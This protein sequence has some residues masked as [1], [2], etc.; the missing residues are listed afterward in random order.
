MI[1]TYSL[2]GAL[3]LLF[4]FPGRI[5]GLELSSLPSEG[6]F[7]TSGFE[8]W[9]PEEGEVLKK[10]GVYL[11]DKSKFLP[12][13]TTSF[14]YSSKPHWI[15][16]PI[17]N[18]G[19]DNI[20]WVL[21]VQ[22]GP[23]DKLDVYL[24]SKGEE[25]IYK[26][27]DSYPFA[28]RPIQYRFPSFPFEISPGTSDEIFIRIESHSALNFPMFA[29]QRE[30]F[31]ARANSE[32]ILLG[33]Y[34][35]SIL[36]MA[37][38]NLFLFLSTRE[39]IYFSFSL[40]VGVGA[41]LQC[42]LNGYAFQYL[43]PNATEWASKSL[44]CFIYLSLSTC[45]DF[46]R[47]YFSTK[48]TNPRIDLALK[49]ILSACLMMVIASYFIPGRFSIAAFFGISSL[50]LVLVLYLGFQALSLNLHAAAFF[51]SAW[52][53]LLLGDFLFIL[54]LANV[55]PHSFGLAFWGVEWGSSL[56]ILLLALG[57]ADRVSELSKDLT[58]RVKDLNEAKQNVE[59]SEMR[60]RNLFEGAEELLITLDQEGKI[61]DINRS[62]SRMTGHLP[63]E[64]IGTKF[65][66]LLFAQESLNHSYGS[67]IANDR[68]EEQLKT[69]K[70]VEFHAEL[71]HKYVME[72]KP[73][74]IRL[75][76]FESEGKKLFLGKISEISEDILSRF[77]LSE[78]MHFTLNNYL[79]NADV[80][81]RQL[82][83]NL[84]QFVGSEVV[85][86][87]RTCVREVLI[88]A[89]EHGNL[90]ISFDEKTDAMKQ[91][92]YMEFIQKRQKEAFYG[93]RTVRVA[94]SLNAKRIGFEISD[95]GEGFDFKKILN[96]DGDRLNEE[97]I[98]HGR[99]IMMTRKVFDIVK[100]NDKGN[101]V[102][103][104]KYLEKPLKYKRE[105]T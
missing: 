34:F 16:I 27:G 96:L 1:R 58:S 92:N 59:Q 93:A 49:T 40:Y 90:G 30:D 41:F 21:E 48:R 60:F 89:I 10:P 77:L 53:T 11:L 86:A 31:F 75:Q 38:Y 6:L 37:M 73:V 54:R 56:H 68:L 84:S 3:F 74:R 91:G 99:G 76:P 15:R 52:I 100:F 104:I 88:N 81:C 42:I 12:A 8:V 4:I 95:E 45:V 63:K 62:V 94:Y 80:L 55:L 43:W 97:S 14:G 33:I 71:K 44:P 28:V 98:T 70:T 105:E 23:L 61:I 25:P 51:L 22:Y 47:I 72:P 5:F 83:S 29:Y 85:T 50:G 13:S 2:T 39:R 24:A 101:R 32:Q 36:V 79:Q 64:M 103:L 19:A 78:S 102:L 67:L 17:R 46:V 66:D 57:I 20:S 65:A 69:R 87:V 7:I 18:S 26:A 82:T 35:G 9:I